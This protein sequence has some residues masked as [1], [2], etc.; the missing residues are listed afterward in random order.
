M[1]RVIS[2]G[3]LP[4][5]VVGG[6]LA[7][8]F[9]GKWILLVAVLLPSLFT[10][11]TPPACSSLAVFIAL[12]VLTGLFESASFPAIFAL[13]SQW[14]PKFERS[15]F[16]GIIDAGGYLGMALTLPFTGWI[17]DAYGWRWAFYLYGVF[18][19][20]WALAWWLWA[21]SGPEDHASITESEALYIVAHR[22]DLTI[23]KQQAA[24]KVAIPWRAIACH[25]VV[26][27]LTVAHLRY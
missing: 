13:C 10:M 24:G 15:L 11:F 5:Q 14:A 19:I 16:I 18:G 17:C 9:G 4:L 25:H 12:R 23:S 7:T 22:A 6:Y 3:Y 2:T 20:V 27:G 26:W 21:A 1:A 8:R